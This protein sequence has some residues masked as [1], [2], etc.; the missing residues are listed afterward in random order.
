MTTQINLSPIPMHDYLEI[1]PPNF[2]RLQGHRI[3]LEHIVE[4]YLDGYG[5]EQIAEDF[6]GVSLTKIYAAITFYLHHKTMVEQYLV[7]IDA[8]AEVAY[9]EWLA[10]PPSAVQQ[11]IQRLKEQNQPPYWRSRENPLD[12]R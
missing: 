9:Q 7:E 6:P 1:V 11:R 5:P 8:Q 2:I 10:T 4:R 12:F 3:G